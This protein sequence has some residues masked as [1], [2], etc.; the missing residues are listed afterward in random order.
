ME[1]F[2]STLTQ[3]RFVPSAP[4]N[5]SHRTARRV[6]VT[7]RLTSL[8]LI[9]FLYTSYCILFRSVIT[10]VYFFGG[11]IYNPT[12][13]FIF[14]HILLLL[15]GIFTNIRP[16][17]MV[18]VFVLL[19][20]I[21]IL[22]PATALAYLQSNDEYFLLTM[23]AAV[24]FVKLMAPIIEEAIPKKRARESLG[25]KYHVNF[26]A[27]YFFTLSILLYLIIHVRG[28]FNLSFLNVYDY[29]LDFN[30]SLE[31]PLNYLLP[32]AAG[33][34][35]G[36]IT[37][38]SID[39][40][41][42]L[43][44][45]S[46]FIIGILFFGFS[47]HKAFLFYPLF[48]AFGYFVIKLRHVGT[49]LILGIVFLGVLTLYSTGALANILSS[50]FANRLIFIPAQ[51]HFFFFDEFS[52]IGAQ[53]WAESKFSLGLVKTN[54][55][56]PAVFYIGEKMTGLTDVGANTGW[57][58]NGY[59]NAG[60]FGIAFYAMLLSCIIAVID[61]LGGIYGRAFVVSAFIIPIF[62]VI[63]SIDLLAGLLTGGLM[64]VFVIFFVFL[65]PADQP[66]RGRV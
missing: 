61:W 40:R 16:Q 33:A 59:M 11:F 60:Y 65:R 28:F 21:F 15:A 6:S 5:G 63:N 29:R 41:R 35:L 30:E 54:L 17:K 9:V 34:C 10:P 38:V 25:M 50:S 32:I 36:F 49:F 31:F 8:I 43:I 46:A 20:L 7:E 24:F 3:S 12:S 26:Y 66:L 42:W 58:A 56:T 37:S 44:A 55:P 57:I 62:S 13:F 45:L 18:D 48:S 23:Y 1:S 52:H 51:I 47:S 19:S 4:V 2:A 14:S 22:A 64:A 39:Q 53:F 27:I